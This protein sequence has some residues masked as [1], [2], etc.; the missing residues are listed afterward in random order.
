LLLLPS[1]GWD[2]GKGEF[3]K[4]HPCLLRWHLPLLITK[5]PMNMASCWD[6]QFVQESR[7]HW[8]QPPCSALL[9]P[10]SVKKK[11]DIFV[12]LRSLYGCFLVTFPYIYVL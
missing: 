6:W 9:F 5:G 4:C 8:Y 10:V 1:L 11:K 2:L 7:S 3:R 12:C